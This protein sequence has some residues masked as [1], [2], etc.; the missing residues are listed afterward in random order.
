MS[1]VGHGFGKTGELRY[2]KGSCTICGR[3]TDTGVAIRGEAEWAHAA[4]RTLGVPDWEIVNMISVI[5]GCDLGKVPVGV[6]TMVI[7]ICEACCD[8]SVFAK[9]GLKPVVLVHEAAVPVIDQPE[10]L[11]NT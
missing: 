2:R 4:L 5:T 9:R 6:F 1:G 11:R 8:R 3:G 7:T 10:H